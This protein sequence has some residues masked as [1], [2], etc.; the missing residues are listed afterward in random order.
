[1]IQVQK[2][3]LQKLPRKKKKARKK[4]LEMWA[5]KCADHFIMLQSK[6][7]ENNVIFIPYDIYN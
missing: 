1:M 7:E 2:F 5:R 3:P 4:A 6:P